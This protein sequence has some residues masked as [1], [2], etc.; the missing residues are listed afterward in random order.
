MTRST[1]NAPA[2]LQTLLPAHLQPAIPHITPYLLTA[3]GSFTRMDYGTG[4]ETAWALFMCCLSLVRFFP[5]ASSPP[6]N[7]P[8]DSRSERDAD[9]DLALSRALVLTI[10]PR[11]VALTWRLQDAYRL[12]PAGSHGVWGLDDSSFLG[13]YWGSAQMRSMYLFFLPFPFPSPF[14]CLRSLF[15][16]YSLDLNLFSFFLSSFSYP[17]DP[18]PHEI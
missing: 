6:S 5:F 3:F 10:F 9:E 12:E 16:L 15:L 7:P 8:P 13:Y 1:K 17:L 18:L 11:Y 4:H 14:S 2:L